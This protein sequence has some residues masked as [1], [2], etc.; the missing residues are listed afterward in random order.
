MKSS[1][2]SR[3]LKLAQMAARVGLKEARSGDLKSR[4]A[5]AK[6]LAEGL[7]NMKGA[8]MKA[9]QLLSLELLDYFPKEAVE[10]LSLLQ[11]SAPAVDFSVIEGVLRRELGDG[12]ISSLS[13]L[14]TTPIGS[15]SIG[16][17]HRAS[18]EGRDLVLKVQYPGIAD[19]IDS[20]LSILKSVMKAFCT[21][22]GRDMNLEPLFKEFRFILE[23]EVDYRREADLQT[24]YRNNVSTI[25]KIPGVNYVVPRIEPGFSTSRVLAMEW[26]SGEN[27]RRWIQTSRGKKEKSEKLAHAVLNLYFHEIFKWGLVQ[28]DPNQGNFLVREAGSE[29]EL[30]LLDFGATRVYS[31][32]F[33]QKYVRLLKATDSGDGAL[34]RKEAIDFGL[35]DP[36]ESE[37]AFDALVQVLVVAV[38]PFD[39]STFDF[40]SEDHARRSHESSRELAAKL[41]YSPPPHDLV[42]LHRKLAGVYAILKSLGVTMDISSYWRKMLAAGA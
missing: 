18:F 21:L 29:L 14:N 26:Q 24:R 1:A 9:G 33:V 3:A 11:S 36:R 41:K 22:T 39:F 34:I 6:I 35:I 16:Q 37:E 42:F 17:V 25:E 32:D 2:F 20:D 12:K 38:R 19:S 8:A 13:L 10:I 40:S 4:M 30:V 27:L 31:R 7:S 5:Q 15:A 28:T 23:Q